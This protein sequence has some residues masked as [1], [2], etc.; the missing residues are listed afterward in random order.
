MKGKEVRW[1]WCSK[2]IYDLLSSTSYRSKVDR[3]RSEFL[4]EYTYNSNAIEGNIK[5]VLYTYKI[6]II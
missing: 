3:L 2:K 5:L 1:Q 4:I 6:P